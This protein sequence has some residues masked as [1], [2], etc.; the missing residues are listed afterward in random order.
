M[1]GII[2]V[3]SNLRMIFY[4]DFKNNLHYSEGIN[5]TFITTELRRK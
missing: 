5:K 4:P 2:L 1:V 3:M